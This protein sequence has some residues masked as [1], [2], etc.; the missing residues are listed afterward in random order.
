MDYSCKL[1]NK[2]S[3]FKEET[4]TKKG[5]YTVMISP[6]GTTGKHGIGLVTKDLHLDSL[7]M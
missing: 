2:E 4:K 6:W 1:R 7:F 5:V 3:Q